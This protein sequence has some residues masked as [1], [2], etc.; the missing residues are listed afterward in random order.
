MRLE[1]KRGREIKITCGRN[2]GNLGILPHHPT[3]N[4]TRL[5]FLLHSHFHAG[6][7]KNLS[8]AFDTLGAL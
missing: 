2:F 8:L 1:R 6:S 5:F 7:W 4:V 3:G